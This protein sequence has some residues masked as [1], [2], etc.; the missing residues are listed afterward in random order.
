MPR[1]F[2]KE[3]FAF[4]VFLV[5]LALSRPLPFPDLL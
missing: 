3:L 2:S 4:F 1:N 5:S